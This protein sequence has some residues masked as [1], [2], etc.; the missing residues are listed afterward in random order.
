MNL[1][2][3]ILAP[4]T[5]LAKEVSVDEIL[6][7]AH[8]G[9]MGILPQHADYMTTLNRGEI[10]YRVGSKEISHNITGGLMVVKQGKATVLVDGLMATVTPLEQ[11]RGSH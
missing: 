1:E 7:P 2:L 11:A 10:T 8:W 3:E 9:Q 4:D 6:I 5:V